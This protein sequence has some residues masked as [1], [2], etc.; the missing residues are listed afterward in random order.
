MNNE[1]KKKLFEE[2]FA[3]WKSMS[4]EEL[5]KLMDKCGAEEVKEEQGIA[6]I[7]QD[8]ETQLLEYS[9]QLIDAVHDGTVIKSEDIKR[10]LIFN[11]NRCEPDDIYSDINIET[12]CRNKVTIVGKALEITNKMM[13]IIKIVDA[14]FYE[15]EF[16]VPACVLTNNTL[17]YFTKYSRCVRDE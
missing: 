5:K 8:Y 17:A 7:M 10:L 12:T 13:D 11:P 2:M 16:D 1:E 14:T 4:D 9:A 6:K 15:C 3:K